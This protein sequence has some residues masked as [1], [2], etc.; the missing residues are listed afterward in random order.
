MQIAAYSTQSNC[1]MEEFSE[2]FAHWP[3]DGRTM[4]HM[5]NRCAL[6]VLAK[7]K[8]RIVSKLPLWESYEVRE[9]RIQKG[10]RPLPVSYFSSFLWILVG[11]TQ[12]SSLCWN[13]LRI[14]LRLEA[15]YSVSA[16]SWL[17]L[18]CVREVACVS[19]PK[20]FHTWNL[21]GFSHI[22]V[23]LHGEFRFLWD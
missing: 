9:E 14:T 13:I 10:K 1:T 4:Q 7:S 18:K 8:Q 5:E 19:G 2:K 21:F 16:L 15:W 12:G 11:K 22:V 20:G 23:F 17:F 3:T 6:I